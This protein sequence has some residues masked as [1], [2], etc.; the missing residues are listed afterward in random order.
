MKTKRSIP[1]ERD[2]R[3]R[4]LTS[5]TE[6]QNSP[7]GTSGKKMVLIATKGKTKEQITRELTEAARKAGLL[8][9]K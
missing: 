5:D 1:R 4:S 3:R 2:A 7:K 9:E 6:S 8:E